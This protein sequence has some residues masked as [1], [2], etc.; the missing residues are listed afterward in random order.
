MKLKAGSQL[1]I[2]VKIGK[3]GASI[4][5][6]RLNWS[7]CATKV[8]KFINRIEVI[9]ITRTGIIVLLA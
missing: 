9:C 6:N 8:Q 7:F 2:K 1:F 4:I 3:I 5:Q